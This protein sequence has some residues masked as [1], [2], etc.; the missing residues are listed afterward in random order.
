MEDVKLSI[1]KTQSFTEIW[2]EGSVEMNGAEYNFWLVDPRGKDPSGR[3]YDVEVRW[4]FKQVP[5]EIRSMH[6]TIVEA[7]KKMKDDTKK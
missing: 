5:R 4:W 6:D 2:Y 3:E 1:N 7:Y